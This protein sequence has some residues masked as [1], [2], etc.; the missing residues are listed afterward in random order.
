MVSKLKNYPSKKYPREK[1]KWFQEKSDKVRMSPIGCHQY[2][3][4]HNET[5]EYYTNVQWVIVG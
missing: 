1:I 4:E 5:N 2:V 3:D